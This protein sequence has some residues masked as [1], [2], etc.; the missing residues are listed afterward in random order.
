MV[1]S[2]LYTFMQTASKSL[3][4]KEEYKSKNKQ[5]KSRVKFPDFENWVYKNDFLLLKK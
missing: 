1:I 3:G 2:V 4:N 5:T